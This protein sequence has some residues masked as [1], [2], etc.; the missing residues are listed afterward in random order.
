MAE[1][2]RGPDGR[3]VG[4][5]GGR[6]RAAPAPLEFRLLGPVEGRRDGVPL[7][8]GSGKS[9]ALLAFLLLSPNRP[10]ST[11]RL[12]EALWG[13]APPQSARQAVQ[14]RVSAV[15]RALGPEQRAL[16]TCER[17][18]LIQVEPEAIDAH[19]FVRLAG[20]GRAALAGGD[21][22][23][24]ATLL[25]QALALWRGPAVADGFDA[26][27]PW[28]AVGWL[29]ERR[30][31]ALEDRI[32]ADLARGRHREL[33]GELRALVTAH[34]LREQ[35]RGQ[36]MLALYR[37]GRQAE[38]LAAYRDGRA[39]T[40]A[41][42]GTE[43]GVELR[44]LEQAILAQDSALEREEPAA[45]GVPATPGEPVPPSPSAERKLVSV[46]LVDIDE[47]AGPGG[48]RDPEDLASLLTERLALVGSA[49][50]RY[51]GTVEQTVAGTVLALFGVP[52]SHGDDPE[53]A[54]RA[55]LAL[56]DAIGADAS[57][58]TAPRGP[59]PRL[60][61][62]VVT[63]EALVGLEVGAGG[64]R[65]TGDLVALC[66]RLV[67]ATP[68]GSVM[69]SA[70]TERATARAVRYGQASL[71][72][73]GGRAE[74]LAV[75][76]ALE[77]RDQPGAERARIGGTPLVGRERELGVLRDAWRRVRGEGRPELVTVVGPPGIGKSRLVAELC[78]PIEQDE[79]GT[80]REG[81][82][83][84][85]GQATTCWALAEV[86]KAEAGI[87]ES[88]SA[89]Q[90]A[91][92]LGAAVGDALGEAD[93]A[94]ATWVAGHLR[95]LL[96]GGEE[97]A[98]L[99]EEGHAEAFAAWRRFLHALA[100][101]RPLVLAVEDLHWADDLLLDFVAGLAEP[102][103]DQPGPVPLLV[104]ATAR[105]ELLERRPEWVADAG[106]LP[107]GPL[108]DA[109]TTR[110]L[111][112]LLASHGLGGTVDA[113]LLARVGGSPLFAEE[114]VRMLRDRGQ[115]AGAAEP[116]LPESVHA[117][118]AARLDA[119]PPQE[120]SVLQDAAVLGQVSRLDA[121]AAVGGHDRARLA[122]CLRRLEADEFVQRS[123][124]PAAANG[125]GA[126][127]DDR[128]EYAFRHVV[129]R[130]VAY[131]QL[132]RAARAERHRRAA[133]W[134]ERLDD[135]EWGR[136]SGRV[137]LL[138][139]HWQ[140][141]LRYAR[142][143]GRDDP[144]LAERART[145]LRAAGDRAAAL[146]AHQAAAGHYRAALDLWPAGDPARPELLLRAGEAACD[147]ERE[148]DELLTE[149][150]DALLGAGD[151]AGAAEAEVLLGRLAMERGQG[152][153]RAACHRR[154]LALVAGAPPSRAKATVLR[155]TAMFHV[156]AGRPAEG[157]E[158]ARQALDI[159]GPLGLRTLELGAL[160]TIGAAQV[161]RGEQRGISDLEHA[162]A[163]F[164]LL[165][166]PRVAIWR[167][168]LA[169]AYVMV[170]DLERAFAAWAR[171]AR[172]AQRHG[173]TRQQR[174]F[175]LAQVAEWFWTGRWDRAVAAVD[176]LQAR[177]EQGKPHFLESLCRLW[178]ARIRLA[179]G[180]RDGAVADA[181]AALTLAREAG[182]PYDQQPAL[183]ILACA[184]IAAGRA[185]EAEALLDELLGSLRG[186][187]LQPALGAG[188][189]FA[190]AC[191]GRAAAA[192]DAAG[193]L[194]SPWLD[195]TRALLAGDPGA[196]AD[197]YA[198][199][200]SRPDEARARLLDG[201]RLL[202]AGRPDQAR[203]QLH[204][205][206]AFWRQVA[207]TPLLREA[208]TLAARTA[209]HAGVR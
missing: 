188:L 61:A 83:L 57:Q 145:A 9:R 86:V 126:T 19:R 134:L 17:G 150:R 52:R 99:T 88:D 209:T 173:F 48:E 7:E 182:D 152:Q 20:Q 207:A 49:V 37:S 8:L 71:L 92:K 63:G 141:A 31:T 14:N 172:E 42:L 194:P 30:L 157:I 3:R 193:A 151:R 6:P 175:E 109:D 169:G 197:L 5:V 68:P 136:P 66:T 132:P 60:R 133:A 143:S 195:A 114:Y 96:V 206:A 69:V 200:G 155:S 72:A 203:A 139:H 115:A 64:Q 94:T 135:G 177:S 50:Q 95:R 100:A 10:V 176:A 34:P 38:A 4:A 118:V 201:Q 183:G 59:G 125:D 53:R 85:Y 167:G 149:A 123:A 76:R 12:I 142:A 73:L 179:R 65:V 106:L 24:A 25:C 138:A 165:R 105:P 184:L 15:R 204:R 189:G 33:A 26:G 156:M 181:R 128:C 147:G 112:A 102:A 116:P 164:A 45:D 28:P 39:A 21:P 122:S 168:N 202:A 79:P 87:R 18:Y 121:L 162:V 196:A 90:A 130:D 101:R 70:T 58:D 80:W 97:A 62:A 82:S 163:G 131:G 160:G 16:V 46:L 47:P 198:R 180:D 2:G 93:P 127:P 27:L 170:G 154:A 120:K 129:V 104:V 191:L 137:D 153:R 107:L 22:A 174:R 36:L 199:I 159:A 77:A 67:Q 113:D 1:S 161:T 158:V 171:A 205:A 91:R 13:D 35:L 29:E 54:V 111:E 110:L 40:V 146:G 11:E 56:R 89:T 74:P 148:G 23:A 178:R 108:P 192:L 117:I 44:R 98:A 81:R 75:W 103:G 187:L 166:S 124:R 186:S 51:G 78:R 140:A 144:T 185:G 32:E 55:A 208:E 119:L 190:L 43:P 41:E 84:P